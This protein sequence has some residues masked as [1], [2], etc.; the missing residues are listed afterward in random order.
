MGTAD[1]DVAIVR[2]NLLFLIERFYSLARPAAPDPDYCDEMSSASIMHRRSG[3]ACVLTEMDR[4]GFV[5]QLRRSGELRCDL[6]TWL[7]GR[8]RD[9]LFA[10][11]VCSTRHRLGPFLDAVTAGDLGLA[12]AI[13]AVSDAPHDPRYQYDDDHWYAQ[14]L[15]ELLKADFGTSAPALQ[16][17]ARFQAV[18]EGQETP[19][20]QACQALLTGNQALFG[21][22]LRGLTA[23]H[24]AEFRE[25]GE[26]IIADPDEYATERFILV[27]G[28]ALKMLARRMNIAV[29]D[30]DRYMP[31]EAFVAAPL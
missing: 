25:K 7:R 5:D 28:L 27:E 10:R 12:R 3:I 23:E 18:V 2:E 1:L 31:R 6:L 29:A 24:E 13:A 11:Y 4:D 14:V 17:L 26:A 21:E 30:E 15:F 9:D 16:H 20:F 19:R 8:E 22:A